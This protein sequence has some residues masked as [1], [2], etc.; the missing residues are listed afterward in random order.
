LLLLAAALCGCAAGL[1][2][3][4]AAPG[5]GGAAAVAGPAAAPGVATGGH[6]VAFELVLSHPARTVRLAAG[7]ADRV[8]FEAGP[9]AGPFAGRLR[10]D[11]SRRQ[12]WV[13]ITWLGDD[14]GGRRF[15]KLV[16][17]AP[18]EPTRVRT[19]DAAG[20]LSHVWELD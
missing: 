10:L 17:E 16:L 3:L 12:V 5:A 6:G 15:A 19:F 11:A 20:E 4:T 1:W 18:G 14:G 13:D 9:G 8:A 2:R 7:P